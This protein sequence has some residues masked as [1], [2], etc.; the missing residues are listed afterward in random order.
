MIEVP[1][2]SENTGRHSQM[3]QRLAPRKVEART[4]TTGIRRQ[5]RLII[6]VLLNF[7]PKVITRQLPV[8][9]RFQAMSLSFRGDR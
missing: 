7:L 5:Q 8:T 9:I 1:A 2:S 4:T 6:G 3:L